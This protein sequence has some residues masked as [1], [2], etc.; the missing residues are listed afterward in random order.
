MRITPLH[1]AKCA[2]L[3]ALYHLDDIIWKVDY[4]R[5]FGIQDIEVSHAGTNIC[6]EL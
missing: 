3:I 1:F 5:A 6:I 4:N 2:V